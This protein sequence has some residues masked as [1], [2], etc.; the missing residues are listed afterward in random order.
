MFA[1][2]TRKFEDAMAAVTFA[3]KGLHEEAIRLMKSHDT[4]HQGKR[5]RKQNQAEAENRPQMQL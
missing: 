2:L 4:K 5:K 3:E 1:M